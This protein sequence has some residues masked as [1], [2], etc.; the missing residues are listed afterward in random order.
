MSQSI[1]YRLSQA[2]VAAL[3]AQF[4]PLGAT[5]RDN[6]TSRAALNEGARVVFVEDEQDQPGTAS[7][8]AQPNQPNQAEARSFAMAVGVIARTDD[9]RAQADADMEQVKATLRDAVLAET[10]SMTAAGDILATAMPLEGQRLYRLDGIDVGGA[11][12]LTRF[13][14]SYRL[15][16][17]GRR[18]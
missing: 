18:S 8:G 15:P 4:E 9:A 10:R 11:L 17:L 1:P 13:L 14:I 7:S 6:P 16:S 2:V 5:V 12:V 3:R